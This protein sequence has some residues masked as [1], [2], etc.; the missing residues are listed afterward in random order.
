LNSGYGF[1]REQT[2]AGI[3]N[4]WQ[5]QLSHAY[6]VAHILFKGINFLHFGVAGNV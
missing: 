3:V 4:V 1:K 2:D 6:I 5:N